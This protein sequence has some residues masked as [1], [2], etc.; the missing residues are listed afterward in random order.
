MIIPEWRNES[1]QGACSRAK[2]DTPRSS[3]RS[4]GHRSNSNK[5]FLS[6]QYIHWAVPHSSHL[7]D[8][9]DIQVEQGVRCDCSKFH[10]FLKTVDGKPSSTMGRPVV[11][12]RF[13][14]HKSINSERHSAE[15]QYFYSSSWEI[16]IEFSS[17]NSYFLLDVCLIISWKKV[18]N[19]LMLRWWL[20]CS[21]SNLLADD[22]PKLVKENQQWR[23]QRKTI[24]NEEVK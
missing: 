12:A 1:R 21:W 6:I 15:L 17:S 22:K 5:I 20:R 7:R 10:N 13:V 9:V 11:I 14:F 23:N 24:K 4:L 2:I 19:T 18:H 8:S 16:E 3:D